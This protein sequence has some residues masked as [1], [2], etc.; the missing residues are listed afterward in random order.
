MM[1]LTMYFQITVL[2]WN[3]HLY[4]MTNMHDFHMA[5]LMFLTGHGIKTRTY[6]HAEIAHFPT[7]S[8]IG[9]W[10]V[11]GLRPHASQ[12]LMMHLIGKCA[13]SAQAWVLAMMQVNH[14]K[15]QTESRVGMFNGNFSL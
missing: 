3:I 11:L 13:I 8:V 14:T 9:T 7:L 2:W 12:V 10:K 6:V 5:A 15:P 1:T 4:P